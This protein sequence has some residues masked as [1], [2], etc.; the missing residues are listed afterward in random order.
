MGDSQD[1]LR[2]EHL[3]ISFP[4]ALRG[5]DGTERIAVV[6]DASFAVGHEETVGLVGESGSGKTISALAVMGLNR[7]PARVDSGQIWFHGKDLRAGTARAMDS[8]RGRSISMIFQTPRSSLNPLMRAGDQIARVFQIQQGIGR[9]QAYDRAREMLRLVGIPEVDRHMH[10]YPH[11]L[12]GGMSQRVLI[13]MMMACEPELLI[14]DEPTTGLD[15]TVQAQI[16]ELI[17]EVQRTR[18]MAVLLITHDLGVIAELCQRMVVMYAGHVMET[19]G[20]ERVFEQ[21]C[22]PYTQMLLQSM[23]RVDRTV[24]GAPPGPTG[25]E[26]I[27]YTLTACRFSPRCPAVMDVCRAVRPPVVSLERGH[28]VMCHLYQMADSQ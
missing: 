2:V 1:L 10:S 11:Q 21:P 23:L 22:H 9:R 6:D 20:V 28:H 14:A 19:G 17:K 5:G 16:F 7:K 4:L 13:A 24:E 27:L 15:V 25:V 18:R 12:S 8:I 26:E 3:S